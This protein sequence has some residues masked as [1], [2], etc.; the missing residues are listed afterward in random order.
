[1]TALFVAP[2][3]AAGLAGS[4]VAVLS[5]GSEAAFLYRQANPGKVERG[6]VERLIKQAREPAPGNRGSRA[7]RATC[8]S[9]AGDELGNPWRC[10]VTYAS[11]ARLTYAVTID[12]SGRLS[13]RTQK[14]T[15]EGCCVATPGIEDTGGQ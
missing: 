4:A 9:G 7:R 13:G 11:G 2:L 1:V 15:V 12:R 5:R 10:V 14:G 8:S 3:V 6:A